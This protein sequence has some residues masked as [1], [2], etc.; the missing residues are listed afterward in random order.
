MWIISNL[1]HGMPRVPATSMELASC[2]YLIA[3]LW[4]FS[5]DLRWGGVRYFEPN[6][7]VRWQYARIKRHVKLDLSPSA[8]RAFYVGRFICAVAYGLGLFQ[9]VVLGIVILWLAFEFTF[10]RKYHTQ[11]LCMAGLLLLGVQPIRSP[12]MVIGEVWA[13]G[14]QRLH[15]GAATVPSAPVILGI[16]GMGIMYWSSVRFK[17]VSSQFMSGETLRRTAEHFIL[18]RNQMPYSEARYP[19]WYIRK[20]ALGAKGRVRARWRPLAVATIGLESVL[21]A[22]LVFQST[23]FAG[24][25]LGTG[26]HLGF[27]VLFPKR[28]MPFTVAVLSFYVIWLDPVKLFWG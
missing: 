14:F 25:V 12:V 20:L 8:Y 22:L 19:R 13:G 26:M 23:W 24:V 1:L 16:V 15:A 10:D 4:K 17:I 3:L 2:G 5:W 18:I 28:L 7:L 27:L 6:S 21:P 9:S 11:F